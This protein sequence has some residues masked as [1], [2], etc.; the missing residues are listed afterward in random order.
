MR[1]VIIEGEVSCGCMESIW[2]V[3][4]AG[5]IAG[6]DREVGG[7]IGAAV[8]GDAAG[9]YA[10]QSCLSTHPVTDFCPYVSLG[11]LSLALLC[12]KALMRA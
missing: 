6:K 5:A 1:E 10:R 12:T 3:L 7:A 9:H 4:F 8:V 11:E 2:K